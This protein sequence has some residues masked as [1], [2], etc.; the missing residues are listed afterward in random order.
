MKAASKIRFKARLIVLLIGLLVTEITVLTIS[1]LVGLEGT[2]VPPM[3]FAVFA[4]VTLALAQRWV[5]VDAANAFEE[6]TRNRKVILAGLP[7]QLVSI[8]QTCSR[9]WFVL[10]HVRLHPELIDPD[11][12]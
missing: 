1:I 4:C 10:L 5:I 3:P 8:S 6:A 12:D 7:P 11:L 9:R 2:K